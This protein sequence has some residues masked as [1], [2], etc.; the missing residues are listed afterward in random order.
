MKTIEEL[1]TLNR[2]LAIALEEAKA[3]QAQAEAASLNKTVFLA[4]MSH[5][6]RTP[7]N[8]IIGFSNLLVTAVDEE[9]RRV[10]AEV[11]ENN[12]SLLLQLIN[13]ILDLSKIESGT[14]TFVEERLELNALLE[15]L[16]EMMKIRISSPDVQLHCHTQPVECF[17][18]TERKMLS[19]VLINLLTNAIKFTEQGSICVEYKVCGQ[20][21]R[22]HVTD[23]GAG[24]PADQLQKIFDRFV[25]LDATK[26]GTGLG[27]SICQ[28]IVKRLGGSIGVDSEPGKGTT[29]W[30]TIPYHPVAG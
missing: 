8:A 6:I 24:I 7:L 19:Q 21:L 3:A 29:F 20:E 14:L 28:T 12:C 11:M 25:R 2:R 10:Y 5:E 22:F 23:T 1:E 18:R 17:V 15:Q 30:F 13:D 4:N 9:E 26:P 16:A 27:L